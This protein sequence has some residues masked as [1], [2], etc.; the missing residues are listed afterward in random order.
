[1][2]RLG[3]ILVVFIAFVSL[4][5]AGF[6]ILVFN[7]GP[8]WQEVSGRI[9]DYKFSLAAGEIPTWSAV[10][11][12]GDVP[13]ASD[14]NLAKV[15]DAVL[16]DKLKRTED[17]VAD[18]ESKIPP[19]TAELAK[20]TTANKADIPA[21]EAYVVAERARLAAFQVELAS[22]QSQVLAQTGVAQKLENVASARRDDVFRLSG[23]LE[24][25]RADQVRL[26]AL[27]R[28]LAED[29]EQVIGNIERAEERQA[30]IRMDL[31][32]LGEQPAE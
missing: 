14:V 20:T 24:Q 31:A 29:L 2:T 3:K 7:A 5:F 28:Q 22:L 15:I 11:A 18:C 21:L 25:I 27:R 23:Q 30:R 16:A 4:A 26:I 13:I 32:T 6:A 8:N 10:L 9:K 1:M 12:V 19:L 17:K